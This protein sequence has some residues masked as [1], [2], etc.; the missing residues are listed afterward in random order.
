MRLHM[1][2]YIY[3]NVCVCVV[4]SC[5]ASSSGAA[6][7]HDQPTNV[8]EPITSVGFNFG[9]IIF[10][11]REIFWKVAVT[12]SGHHSLTMRRHTWDIPWDE[13]E[14]ASGVSVGTGE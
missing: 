4:I 1:R 14:S 6:T 10:T 3:H 7:N 8:P 9:F 2:V 5:H 13:C 11:N 12:K